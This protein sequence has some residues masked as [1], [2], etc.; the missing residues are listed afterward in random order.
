MA[1][2]KATMPVEM[3]GNEVDMVEAILTLSTAVAIV[4]E[5]EKFDNIDIR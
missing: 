3:A 5:T 2:Y 4:E 1:K